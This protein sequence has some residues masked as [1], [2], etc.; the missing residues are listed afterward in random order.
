[1]HVFKL[2]SNVKNCRLIQQGLVRSEQTCPTH[3]N[4]RLKLGMYSDVTKFPY[5]GGYV[6]I[7]ECCP[8][9]FISVFSGSLFEGSQHP[10]SVILKLIYHWACQTNVQNVVQWVHK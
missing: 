4:R 9:K 1:M 7:S 10:P 3:T 5:S 6:W 2:Y 8:S